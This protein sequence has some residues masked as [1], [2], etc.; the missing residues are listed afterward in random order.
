MNDINALKNLIKRKRV[1]YI[2]PCCAKKKKDG[3]FMIAPEGQIPAGIAPN[4]RERLYE[5]RL[6]IAQNQGVNLNGSEFTPDAPQAASYLHAYDRYNGHLY[7]VP[8]VNALLQQNQPL[9]TIMSALYGLLSPHDYIQNYDLE[10]TKVEHSWIKLLPEII[11]DFAARNKIDIIVGLFGRTTAYTCVF[12]ALSARPIGNCP[13]FSVHT[14]GGGTVR[15]LRGLGHALLYLA[16]D[17]PIPD[18]FQYTIN[19]VRP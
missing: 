6:T 13:A 19:Q 11:D 4:L 7:K 3:V 14:K 9:I 2:I 12:Q 5:T 1:L 10:M 17:V 16:N 18:S 8:G 15:I